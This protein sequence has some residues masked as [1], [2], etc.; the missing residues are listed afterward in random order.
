MI[1]VDGINHNLTTTARG[2]FWRLLAGDATYRLRAHAYGY[3]TSPWE[4]I[5]VAKEGNEEMKMFRLK[6][7]AGGEFV[8]KTGAVTAEKEETAVTL[9][10]GEFNVFI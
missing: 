2:E 7:E 8:V 5:E 6:R 3:E 10:P 9:R 4:S 1:E